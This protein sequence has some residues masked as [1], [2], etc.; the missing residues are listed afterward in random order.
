[1]YIN[2]S[3]FMKTSVRERNKIEYV[4][5]KQ[6]LKYDYYFKRYNYNY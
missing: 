3:H 4:E 2:H 5:I 6:A 1:M